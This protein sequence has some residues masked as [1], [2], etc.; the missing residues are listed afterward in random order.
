MFKF[1]K[2]TA[3]FGS[4]SKGK[5]ND[6]T[7]VTKSDTEPTKFEIT[8]QSVARISDILEIAVRTKLSDPTSDPLDFVSDET[9]D[10]LIID[11]LEKKIGKSE[12]EN[13]STNT[14]WSVAIRVLESGEQIL[15]SDICENLKSASSTEVT[16]IVADMSLP[17]QR[18]LGIVFAAGEMFIRDE[19]SCAP[20]VLTR[21]ANVFL[22]KL[23][24][25][26]FVAI[27]AMVNLLEDHRRLF[28]SCHTFARK[29]S[30][31]TT[32][33]TP[34]EWKIYATKACAVYGQADNSS[35]STDIAASS[36]TA[37][38]VNQSLTQSSNSTSVP[39]DQ[40]LIPSP[41]NSEPTLPATT[42]SDRSGPRSAPWV[43]SKSTRA[44]YTSELPLNDI[45]ASASIDG[46]HL[47]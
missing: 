36:S 26:S 27:N 35:S 13:F 20:L 44:S 12:Y 43:S 6:D 21:L 40:T 31:T 15:S 41:S 16:K 1:L 7:L 18:L 38:S 3:S 22:W 29:I 30:S 39:G 37:V 28:P 47:S 32:H 24:A 9:V 2:K 34:E 8:D 23:P 5:M 25:N 45:N 14:L 17:A 19:P 33:I 46:E 11:F 10:S 42:P 4:G